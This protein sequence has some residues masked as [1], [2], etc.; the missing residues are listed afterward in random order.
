MPT[1]RTVWLLCN[2]NSDVKLCLRDDKNTALLFVCSSS[3]PIA[4][5][6]GKRHAMRAHMPQA[7]SD[8]L[9]QHSLEDHVSL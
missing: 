2:L 5:E 1:L 9:N 4:G 3:L 6:H 8:W 7:V